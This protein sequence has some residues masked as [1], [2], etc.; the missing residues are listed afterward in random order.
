M[1]KMQTPS[2][3]RAHFD[4]ICGRID[5]WETLPTGAGAPGAPG[6]SRDPEHEP[7]HDEHVASLDR[8]ILAGLVSPY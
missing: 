4:A 3:D 7:D 8:L 5:D 1:T 2:E 6:A